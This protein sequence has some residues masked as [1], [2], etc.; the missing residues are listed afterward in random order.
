MRKQ[1]YG[2]YYMHEIVCETCC[3]KFEHVTRTKD[4]TKRNCPKC[5]R[6]TKAWKKKQRRLLREKENIS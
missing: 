2:G 3:V 6:R 5:E 1:S 4:T